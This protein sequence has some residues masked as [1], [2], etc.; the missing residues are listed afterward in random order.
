MET[1]KK[2]KGGRPPKQGEKQDKQLSIWLNVKEY[3]QVEKQASNARIKIGVYGREILLKGE[4]KSRLSVEQVSQLKEVSKAVTNLNQ[5]T[6]ALSYFANKDDLVGL[7][8]RV[9]EIDSLIINLRKIQ[10]GNDSKE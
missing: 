3:A 1:I 4:V 9:S 5:L 7:K 10:Y 8:S 6:K 2:N